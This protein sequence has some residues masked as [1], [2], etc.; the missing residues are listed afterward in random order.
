MMLLL[1]YK[2]HPIITSGQS[3]PLSS[4]LLITL[5]SGGGGG[6][7]ALCWRRPAAAFARLSTAHLV[8]HG[9]IG[10]ICYCL[11]PSEA[12][13]PGVSAAP[14]NGAVDLCQMAASHQSWGTETGPGR[15]ST[16]AGERRARGSLAPPDSV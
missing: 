10:F 16:R 13:V 15:E 14:G 12:F 11:I 8:L 7:L 2:R 4:V 9:L 1:Y 5:E 6:G 3:L